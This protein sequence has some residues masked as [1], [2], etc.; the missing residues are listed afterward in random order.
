[1]T[2]LIEYSREVMPLVRKLQDQ[3]DALKAQKES[4][5][6]V[7]L[8][9]Q[10]VKIAQKALAEHLE[11]DDS[12]TAM[13]QE[14]KETSKEIQQAVKAASKGSGY[15]SKELKS[16]FFDRAKEDAVVKKVVIGKLYDQLNDEINE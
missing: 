2:K 9:Q 12:V 11:S 10:N 6:Q 4:D 13:L 5:E 16:Y 15:K 1:M 14:I 7:V 3:K 8:L